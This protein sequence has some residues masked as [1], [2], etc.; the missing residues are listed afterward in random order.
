MT[1]SDSICVG[2]VVTC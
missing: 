1:E 2:S